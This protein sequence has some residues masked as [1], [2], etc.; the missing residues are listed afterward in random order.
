MTYRVLGLRAAQPIGTF[1]VTSIP[2]CKLR[3]MASVDVRRIVDIENEQRGGIQRE[4]NKAR[5]AEIRKY[6]GMG[7][8]SFPNS[9]ILAST[10]DKINIAENLDKQNEKIQNQNFQNK[11]VLM[12]IDEAPDTFKIIDGQHRLYGF[13]DVNC[14][15]YDLIVTIFIDLPV[16]DQAYMFSTINLKQRPVDRS[17]VYDLYEEA[18][19]YSPYKA[20]HNVAKLLNNEVDS[21]L[22][23]RIKLLGV[24]PR[25]EGEI[26]Y[27]APLSQNAVVRELL[28][29]ISADPDKDRET[30]RLGKTVRYSDEDRMKGLIFREFYARE[31]DWAIYA[32][33]RNYFRSFEKYFKEEWNG[34]V[35]SLMPK[36][37]GYGALMRVLVPLYQRAAHG[38]DVSETAFDKW[39]EKAR[40]N[41]D[42]SDIRLNFDHFDRAGSVEPKVAK[43]LLQLFEIED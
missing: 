41:Y 43:Y 42:A 27:R 7:D 35:E 8:S 21:P 40:I 25:F 4:R 14:R 39:F 32:I 28:K 16:E 10:S 19:I 1:Y 9:I 22:Y 17:L 5:I 2:A 33:M 15:E 26:L 13:D 29:L 38:G 3:S 37:V 18:N 23:K 30:A 31:E 24:A 6:I 20:A 36:T 11:T 12:E 34:E